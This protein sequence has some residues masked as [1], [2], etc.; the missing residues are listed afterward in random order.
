MSG[1]S[2]KRYRTSRRRLT[3]RLMIQ[4][5]AAGLRTL[6]AMILSVAGVLEAV[7]FVVHVLERIGR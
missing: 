6:I 5:S 4:K 7:Q 1:L 2:A 3:F